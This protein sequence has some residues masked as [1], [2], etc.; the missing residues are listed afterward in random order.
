MAS[1]LIG[2][3]I[4][5]AL[6]VSPAE[7]AR[8]Q[9]DLAHGRPPAPFTQAPPPP[10]P[11]PNPGWPTAPPPRQNAPQ[12]AAPAPAPAPQV[13]A[14]PPAAPAPPPGPVANVDGIAPAATQASDVVELLSGFDS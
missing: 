10:P 8:A 6:N 14:P 12:P 11:P 13:P 1:V 9:D 4:R 2:Y 7:L 3:G 5:N